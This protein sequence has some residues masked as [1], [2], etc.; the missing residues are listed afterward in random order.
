M[1]KHTPGPW[2]ASGP[3]ITTGPTESDPVGYGIAI[4]LNPY[5]G[6]VGAADRVD[7]NA[8]LISAAPNLLTALRDLI[9][10]AA[11]VDPE[12]DCDEL[13]AARAAIAKATREAA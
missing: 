12:Q 3:T 7:A 9:E 13:H 6:A 8:A 5:A 10:W 4:L 1:S 2:H 11:V